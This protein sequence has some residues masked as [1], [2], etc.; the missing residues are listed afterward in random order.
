MQAFL[1]VSLGSRRFSKQFFHWLP[2]YLVSFGVRSIDIVVFD[3][4]EAVNYCAFSGYDS[5]RARVIAARRGGEIVR[6]IRRSLPPATPDGL[7]VTVAQSS[8]RN[9]ILI[10]SE[11]AESLLRRAREQSPDLR[12]QLIRQVTENLSIRL[13]GQPSESRMCLALAATDYL[14]IEAAW[15]WAYLST[16]HPDLE[17][18]PGRSQEFKNMVLNGGVIGAEELRLQR[19]PIFLDCSKTFHSHTARAT[20][21]HGLMIVPNNT[22]V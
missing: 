13:A 10:K 1:G 11:H 21:T 8:D 15:S 22:A 3:H 4:A 14:L 20:T 19:P 12:L 2:A 5:E 16:Y 7:T 9:A 6:M 18:Y 17:V